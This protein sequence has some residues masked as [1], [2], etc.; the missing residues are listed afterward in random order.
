VQLISRHE[1]VYVTALPTYR[2][3]TVDLA[4]VLVDTSAASTVINADVATILQW[5][6]LG[7]IHLCGTSAAAAACK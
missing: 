5:I 3:T 4:D 1:L 2:G 6:H 7:W